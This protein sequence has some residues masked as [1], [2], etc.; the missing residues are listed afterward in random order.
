MA[1]QGRPNILSNLKL[2]QALRLALKKIKEGSL[3]EATL[4][5]HDILLKFP[6][7]KKATEGLKSLSMEKQVAAV[8]LEEPPEP[9]MQ[10]LIKLYS[11]GKFKETITE[12]HKA[13]IS[14]PN[15]F[16]LHNLVGASH[17]G[18]GQF[19]HAIRSYRKALLINKSSADAYFNIG[20]VYREQVKLDEAIEAYK[21]ALLLTPNYAAAYINMGISLREQGKLDDAVKAFTHAISLKPDYS[22]AYNNMGTALKHKGKLKEAMEAYNR[23]LKLKP[24]YSEAHR[25]LG[26]ALLSIGELKKGLEEYEWRWKT[27]KNISKKRHFFQPQWNGKTKLK[28]KTILIWGE[29]GPQDMI[30]WSSCLNYLSAIAEHCILECPAKLVPLFKRSFPEIEVRVEKESITTDFDFHLPMGS[31]YMCFSSEVSA[32]KEKVAFLKTDPIRTKYWKKVLNDLA[33]GPFVGISWKSPLIT[34]SRS[35]NYAEILKW[36]P[37]LSIPNVTFINLQSTNFKSDLDTVRKTLGVTIHNFEE[38]DHY[39]D[40]DDVAALCQALDICISVSTAVGAV[41][42]GVG[43]ATKIAAWKQSAWNNV[44]LAPY[45]PSV[46]SYERNTWEPWEPIFEKIATDVRNYSI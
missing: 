14:Y 5:Y 35:P 2:D 22:E 10:A 8:K 33:E 37:V 19:D 16:I 11:N 21:K 25:N 9:Q 1:H 28:N 17:K 39:D 18:L 42:A 13:L 36:K 12:A 30:I 43:A 4:I 7:N 23:A 24:N 6:R 29:Q 44:L 26:F 38:L 20:N 3:H 27:P 45:G 34:P 31:L 40:L 41:A 15:S 46:V 32:R